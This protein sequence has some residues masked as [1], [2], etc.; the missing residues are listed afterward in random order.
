MST[1]ILDASPLYQEWIRSATE[2]GVQ[3][4]IEQGCAG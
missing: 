3:E 1:E 4:G 2:E